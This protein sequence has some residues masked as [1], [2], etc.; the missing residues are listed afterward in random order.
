MSSR[1]RILGPSSF[2]PMLLD[3]F[4]ELTGARSDRWALRAGV[5]IRR[6]Q[7]AHG[8]SPTFR[9]LFDELVRLPELA[10]LALRAGFSELEDPVEFS[11][12][13]HVAVHWR[14]ERWLIWDR[15]ARSLRV[16]SRFAEESRKWRLERETR[17]RP[18]PIDPRSVDA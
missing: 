11:F 7:K 10:G 17:N 9:E 4:Q 16:G 15:T 14:R 3:L 6:Y 1:L 13:H 8:R 5:I 12:M 2:D 18:E